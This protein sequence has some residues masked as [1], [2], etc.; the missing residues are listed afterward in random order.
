MEDAIDE[1]R[2]RCSS[3]E[4]LHESSGLSSSASA[5]STDVMEATLFER[6]SHDTLRFDLSFQEELT[7]LTCIELP[8]CSA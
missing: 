8:R 6:S 5:S 3:M 7:L 1:L 2:D 4:D